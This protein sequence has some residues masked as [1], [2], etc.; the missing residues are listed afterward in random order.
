MKDQINRYA[1][2]VFEYEP[3]IISVKDSSINV[4]VDRNRE[5]TGTI[6][7]GSVSKVSYI[8]IMIKLN[9]KKI[10]STETIYL[11]NIWLIAMMQLT[12]IP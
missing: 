9:S 10:L 1:R 5:H 2:G 8:L 6:E 3:E 12:V 11:F 7:F 4:I